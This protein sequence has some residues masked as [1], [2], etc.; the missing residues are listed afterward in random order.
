MSGPARRFFSGSSL[1]QA[2]LNAARHHGCSPEEIEYSEVEKRHGLLTSRRSIVIDVNPDSPTRSHPESIEAIDLE[3]P[4]ASAAIP[5]DERRA[6][7][8]SQP[9]GE[10][11]EPVPPEPVP[12]VELQTEPPETSEPDTASS[13][14]KELRDRPLTASEKHPQASGEEAEAAEE[15][16]AK[17]FALAGLD[18]EV[19]V[20][21]GDETLLLEAGG[22]DKERLL[23]DDGSVL[24]AVQHLIPRL[25]WGM[26]GR[27]VPVRVDSDGFHEIRREKLRHLAQ[28]AAEKVRRRG[29]PWH[30]NPMAPDQRRIVHMALADDPAVTTESVGE[31]YFK[32]VRVQPVDQRPDAFDPYNR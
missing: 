4:T 12:E 17:L 22:V 18:C 9:G 19:E 21:E 13:E 16:A 5:E 7:D 24:L 15:A 3:E 10:A 1:Q 30:L 26:V 29:R 27:T 28:V 8:E 11:P 25:V 6:D 23:A 14:E 32:R 31:G 20:F 2:L